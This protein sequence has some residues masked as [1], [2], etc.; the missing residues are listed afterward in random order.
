MLLW[1]SYS[2]WGNWG[3]QRSSN[4]QGHIVGRQ[5]RLTLDSG[6]WGSELPLWHHQSWIFI[7][8][9]DAEAEIPI[10]WPPDSKNWF[11]GKD[12]DA[13]KDWGKEEKGTT[14]DEM[15]GWHHRLN[16]RV[17]SGSWWWTGR[18]GMLQSVGSQRV[19][20]DWLTELNW[21]CLMMLMVF[22]NRPSPEASLPPWLANPWDLLLLWLHLLKQQP[23]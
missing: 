20:H 17:N 22:F 10:L 9:T 3:T 16:G 7:G 18:P 5:R 13:G 19:R 1:S 12:P 6:H 11:I 14:E 15:V 23:W 4:S 21:N 8:R 2:K